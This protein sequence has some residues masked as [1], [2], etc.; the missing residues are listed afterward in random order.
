V[1]DQVLADCRA[2][3]R[4][5][6]VRL[7]NLPDQPTLKISTD[8]QKLQALGITAANVN[9]TL[10]TAWGGTYV[11]DFVDRDRVKRVYVMGD[12]PFRSRPE[13]LNNWHVRG[14][15]GQMVPFSTFAS[16]S[17]GKAPTSLLRFNAISNYE[18]SGQPAAGYSS[19]DSMNAFQEIADKYPG[20]GVAW[21]G[22]SYQE[23]LA[24]GQAPIL[25]GVSLIVVFLCLA[26]LYESWSVPVAVLLVIPLGLVGAIA[27]VTLRGLENDVYLQIGLTTTMGLAAKNAILMIEFAE[28]EVHKGKGIWRRRS[29]GQDPPAPDPD[30]LLRLH[31]RRAAAGSGPW[32]GRQCAH[33]HRHGGD[34]RH[35][36][37]DG[38]GGV[39]HPA[40]LRADPPDAQGAVGEA[41]R[42]EGRQ[43]AGGSGMSRL[44]ALMALVGVLTASAAQAAPKSDG[45]LPIPAQFPSGPA[46]GAPGVEQTPTYAYR[47]VLAD[48]RLVALIEQGW[49]IIRISLRRWPMCRRRRRNSAL[50]LRALPRTGCQRWLDPRRP[51]AGHCQQRQGRFLQCP[52]RLVLR[53]GPV[54]TAARSDGG[55]ARLLSRHAG[56]GAQ[57]TAFGGLQHRHGLAG[58]CRRHQPA[59]AGA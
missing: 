13:D 47:D 49:C 27:M 46:Y 45:P 36:D 4:L 40:V 39:L 12:G 48:P 57:R 28:A 3:K 37:G 14:A 52:G 51:R 21:S 17:W 35:A 23:R 15:D 38:A 55:G 10:S 19:G 41:A 8:T 11:N 50:P 2:D 26:A 33:R 25:Y 59:Q 1:R 31:L 32:R 24:G 9:N 42:Q 58:L 29:S 44:P 22:T 54:R 56:G 30:D 5:A 6:N 7:T 16:A 53:T 20:V 18:F 43:G 34:R